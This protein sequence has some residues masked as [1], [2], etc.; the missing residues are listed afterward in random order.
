M[1]VSEVFTPLVAFM[2][3]SGVWGPLQCAEQFHSSE[4][5]SV[6]GVQMTSNSSGATALTEN[7]EFTGSANRFE[8]PVCRKLMFHSV[9]LISKFKHYTSH[10]YT[11]IGKNKII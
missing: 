7:T 3:L 1:I 9:T 6:W 10:V 11:H 5:V 4:T 2:R 8:Q